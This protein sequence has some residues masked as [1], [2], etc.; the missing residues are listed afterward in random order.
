VATVYLAPTA[1]AT[2]ANLPVA[3]PVAREHLHYLENMR[4]AA[5][6][7]VVV[8]H[9]YGLTWSGTGFTGFANDPLL[10]F[11]AGATAL[12]VF[13]SG[14]FFHHVFSGRIEYPAFIAK[15][16]RTLLPPY[17]VMTVV[18]VLLDHAMGTAS[19][20]YQPGT[21]LFERTV[22]AA[23]TGLSAPAMWY[24][25]FIFDMFLLT[26]V[27][28]LF[29]RVPVRV[30]VAVLAALLLLGLAVERDGLNPLANLAHFSFYYAFGMFCSLHRAWFERL[31]GDRRVMLASVGVIAVL[32]I[33][34]YRVGQAEAVGLSAAIAPTKFVYI[35]KIAQILL[36]AGVMLAFVNRAVPGMRTL[37]R[38]SFGLYFVHQIPLILLTPFAAR[39]LFAG[40]PGYEGLVLCAAIV[41]TISLGLVWTGRTVLGKRSP[42]VIGA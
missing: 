16:A 41:L 1:P 15:K 2:I 13:I 42:Y 11:I 3:Q 31:V 36:L 9:C 33:L 30:Q 26:P 10:S 23:M 20:R 28:V 32:A 27:F 19:I 5:I 37:A 18:L 6:L 25:P 40:L 21:S 35:R 8:S 29:L 12:F 7:M 39:G 17:L 22:M 24:I 4:A 34:Q 38:W 14:F